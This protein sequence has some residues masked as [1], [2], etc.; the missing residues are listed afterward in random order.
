[1]LGVNDFESHAEERSLFSPGQRLPCEVSR[2]GR[3][4]MRF[5][6]F[7]LGPEVQRSGLNPTLRTW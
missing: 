5:P 7:A 4:M 1:M 2:K 3:N 6:F